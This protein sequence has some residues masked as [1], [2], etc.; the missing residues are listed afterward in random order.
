VM[1]F[2]IGFGD[3]LSELSTFTTASIYLM[4]AFVKDVKLMPVYDIT[5][6]FGA[7]LILL[8][9]VNMMLVGLA[10]M[11][12]MMADA[13][14]NAK[15]NK[16]LREQWEQKKA[17]HED[18]PLEEFWRSSKSS[19]RALAIRFVPGLYYRYE[20]FA[21]ERAAAANGPLALGDDDQAKAIED[22]FMRGDDGASSESSYT[23]SEGPGGRPSPEE[24]KRAI[25][26]MSGRILSEI[27]VV[28]IEIK[29][30]IHD[31]CERLA[32]M[33]MAVEELAWRTDKVR[34]DQEVEM[35]EASPE[36]PLL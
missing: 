28:G 10:L 36:G 2:N 32:Q 1:A 12:A 31:V 8:F 24:L 25:E 18:E 5:P 13:L 30:E 6:A 9:Y 11:L 14:F 15:Y 3:K 19:T 4:R 20:K 7:A 29:S 34:T 26:H 27:T 33:Q 23:D 17:F 35:V 21:A 16:E 22:E